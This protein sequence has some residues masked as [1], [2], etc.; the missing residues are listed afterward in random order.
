MV[1]Q[2]IA[3]CLTAALGGYSTLV[4]FPNAANYSSNIVRPYNLDYQVRPAAVAFPQN[5]QQVAAVVKCAVDFGYKVQ[6]K[7]GGHSYG[8][9]GSSTGEISV[10]L[11]NLQHFAMD[12][13][14]HVATIGAGLLLA[15]VSELLYNAGQRF[16]PHGT[17]LQV[18]IGGHA[19]V[20]GAGPSSRLVGLTLDHISSVEVVLANASVTTA[21]LTQNPDLFFAL[22]GAGASFGIIT[23]FQFRTEPA[24]PQTINYVFTW[25]A[26]DAASRAAIFKSWQQYISNS[27]LPRQLSSTLTM[28][29]F[30]SLMAGAYFGSRADFDALRIAQFFPPASTFTAEVFT[31][32]HSLTELW[33]QQI[34]D[35]GIADPSYF[36]AKSLGFR[37]ATIIPDA[38]VDNMFTYLS[39]T[40]T[41]A[42]FWALNFEVGLGA[43]A[44]VAIN[45]TANPARDALYFMLSYAKSA[46]PVTANTTQF[47]NGLNAVAKSAHPSAFYGEYVGYV[48]PKEDDRVARRNYWGSNLERLGLVK[49]VWDPRDVFHNQ[50][51][52]RVGE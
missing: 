20:G 42:A 38:V 46:G 44:D 6:P 26:T 32:Y 11:G 15:N 28:N 19:T 51:S 18:G 52:V 27:T 45:A 43:I 21:S 3:K 16:I 7:S 47:L 10:N 8:N 34:Q 36:Y 41:D 5:T 2:T 4:V 37:P 1:Y 33:G 48:D 39:A 12:D 22:R 17:C 14:T 49:G 40:K 50:Q 13:S 31:N 25:N 24:P 35:S 23:S 30:I 9:Y 29:P